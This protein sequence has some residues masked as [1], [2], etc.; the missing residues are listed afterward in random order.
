MRL[1]QYLRSNT[2]NEMTQWLLLCEY[3]MTVLS[4]TVRVR[5]ESGPSPVRVQSESGPGTVEWKRFPI[6]LDQYKIGFS[7]DWSMTYCENRL[8]KRGY[9]RLYTALKNKRVM[10]VEGIYVG[11]SLCVGSHVT[12]FKGNCAFCWA[13]FVW[14]CFLWANFGCASFVW[15]LEQHSLVKY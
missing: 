15:Q 10:W 13:N 7:L 14:V 2:S 5:S 6:H 1:K 12:A 8:T 4:K 3:I 9:S 11:A